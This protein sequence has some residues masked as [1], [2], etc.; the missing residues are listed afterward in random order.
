MKMYEFRIKFQWILF[1]GVK[2][3]IFQHWFIG[4][5]NGLAPDRRQA[6]IWTNDGKYVDAYMRH[7]AS[8]C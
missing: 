7:S 8:I 3:A 5:D 1:L 4:S 6:I 2:L